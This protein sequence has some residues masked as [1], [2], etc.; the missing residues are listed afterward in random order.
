LAL[1]IDELIRKYD[2]LVKRA[3]DL[4]SYL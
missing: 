4:R 2:D 3:S 1:N